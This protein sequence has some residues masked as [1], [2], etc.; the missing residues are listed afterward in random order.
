MFGL[1]FT[2]CILYSIY[3]II[4]TSKEIDK[5]EIKERIISS[6]NTGE[7]VGMSIVGFA[8]AIFGCILI[9]IGYTWYGV[10]W[11][12]SL[13]IFNAHQSAKWN[14]LVKEH[15]D[16]IATTQSTQTPIP[17]KTLPDA[18]DLAKFQVIIDKF[19]TDGIALINP[20]PILEPIKYRSKFGGIPDLPEGVEWPRTK[21]GLYV[22]PNQALHF[23]AQI[24]LSEMP[25]LDNQLP[26]TGTL[27]FFARIDEEM[28]WGDDP[29]NEHNDVSVI[30]DP[31]SNGIATLPPSDT[32]PIYDYKIEGFK[33]FQ[34]RPSQGVT[35]FQEWPLVPYKIKTLP[36]YFAIPN[37]L[38][39]E[40][41]NELYNLCIWRFRTE[42]ISKATG[43][44][45]QNNLER[46]PYS[47]MINLP[48]SIH[49]IID[50]F[51]NTGFPYCAAGI[52]LTCRNLIETL[53]PND[54]NSTEFITQLNQTASKFDKSNI[55]KPVSTDAAN[56]FI[57]FLNHHITKGGNS[58]HW[59]IA[60]A[61][62]KAKQY[63]LV[64]SGNDLK[65]AKILPQKL[66]DDA[67]ASFSPATQYLNAR[68]G[69]HSHYA[70]NYHQ[71]L[72]F[73]KSTQNPKPYDSTLKCLLQLD[74]M[75]EKS[76]FFCDC[77][78]A[79]FWLEADA[80][81]AQEFEK[82]IGYTCGG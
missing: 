38:L 21:A 64:C 40:D 55:Y 69:S 56:N 46:T 81:K 50:S 60:T 31:D 12:L 67:M 14:K 6:I 82:A 34:N 44:R 54:P 28:L 9:I 75:T 16:R 65:L 15:N 33:D 80:L 48:N 29:G 27:L 49:Q 8:A 5:G 13:Y 74:S 53:D 18:Q 51:E 62:F 20:F 68:D 73:T 76:V 72:G 79:E 7:P 78:E 58:S 17:K 23:M 11:G 4:Q 24:D 32:L 52:Y 41:A 71:I 10:L 26:R 39:P 47:P 66:F 57:K 36:D 37:D 25:E 77:G 42:Q 19:A 35:T 59:P 63:L 1:F 70:A 30:F 61:I 45:I 22:E 3:M 43:Q 2:G